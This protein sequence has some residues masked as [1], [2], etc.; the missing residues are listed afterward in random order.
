MLR[1]DETYAV[2]IY[3]A[4]D[5]EIA[6]II[7]HDRRG[8]TMKNEENPGNAAGI[9][10]GSC[11]NAALAAALEHDYAAPEIPPCRICGGE[12]SIG[13]IGGGLPTVYYC[14]AMADAP[15][16]GREKDWQHYGD[17]KWAAPRQTGDLRVLE[18]VRRFRAVHQE[19]TRLRV[20]LIGMIGTGDP[21][22]LAS[23]MLTVTASPVG[24][25]DQ[26]IALNAIA[27]LLPD[28]DVGGSLYV[29]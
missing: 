18:L 3:D 24:S 19:R 28:P 27:A 13:Q 15:R 10:S 4:V 17:S 5:V 29:D 20:A 11:S 26:R 23:M 25:E 7:A 16:N 1:Y 22:E 9:D 6:R 21:R 12:L 2:E 8:G 14:T